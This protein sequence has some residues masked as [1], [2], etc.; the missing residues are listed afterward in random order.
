VSNAAE[1]HQDQCGRLA[2]LP[3]CSQDG[4]LGVD[5]I[6]S[7]GPNAQSL[8]APRLAREI[9]RPIFRPV[10]AA[11]E[12]GRTVKDVGDQYETHAINIAVRRACDR[13]GVTR[14]S[15]GR[16]RHNYL[17]RV[18]EALDVD[19]A[20]EAAS[21]THIATTAIYIDARRKKADAAAKRCG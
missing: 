12:A 14:W 1:R 15:V 6:I 9:D 7:L 18:Y 4:S 3:H 20:R 8:I 2:L 11:Q 21:H 17:T 19:A 16:L 5:R 13:A 10:D